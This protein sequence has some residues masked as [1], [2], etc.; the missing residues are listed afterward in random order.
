MNDDLRRRGLDAVRG[1]RFRQGVEALSHYVL[2]ADEDDLEARLAL[3]IAY[4]ATGDDERALVILERLSQRPPPNP[5]AP[6]PRTSV[7]QPVS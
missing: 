4:S 7:H 5:G 2:T 1:R 6:T 3:A